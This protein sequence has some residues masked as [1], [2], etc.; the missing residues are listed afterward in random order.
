M[1]SERVLVVDDEADLR[2]NLTEALIQDGYQ[3]DAAAD[4]AEAQRLMGERHYA[5]VL[6]DLNMPGGPS[7]FQLIEAVRALDP[8]TLCVVITGFA[9]MEAAIRAVKYG[10]YDFVQKPFKL[11]ELEAVLDRALDHAEVVGQ[12]RDYQRD[13]EDRVV[14]RVRELRELHEEVLRLNDLLIGAQEE[15]AEG[16]ILERFLE[17]LRGRLAPA[18]C[19]ALLPAPGDAWELLLSSGPQPLASLLSG[20]LPPPPSALEEPVQWPGRAECPEGWLVPL[21]VG[22]RLFGAVYLGFPERTAF[23]PDETTFVLWRRQVEAAL[24]GLR[25]LRLQAGTGAAGPGAVPAASHAP[26]A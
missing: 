7:G 24:N 9:S 12:L 20:P 10:A 17:H 25:R 8:L 26:H 21:Q 6:T 23:H 13:L 19:L 5:V 1:T 14:A 3:V 15:L 11:D 22:G 2:T 4:A 16:P 18:E